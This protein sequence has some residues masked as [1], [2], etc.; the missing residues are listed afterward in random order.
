MKKKSARKSAFF[1]P[2][3]LIGLGL[4]LIGLLLALL[5]YTSYPG[6]SLLA[7]ES[8]QPA[9]QQEAWQ[10][11]WEVIPDSHHD[12][13]PPLRDLALLPMAPSSEHEGPENPSHHFNHA[14][15]DRPDPVVQTSK[16][17]NRLTANIPAPILNFDGQV[18]GVF[19]TIVCPDTNGYVGNTTQFAG[20]SPIG[21]Y[22]QTINRNYQIYDKF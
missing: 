9:P 15:K 8:S 1:N 6:A 13:S 7:H 22:A 16:L 12:L 4:C 10:P 17:L 11:H 3:A 14:G 18:D 20:G 2:R 5:A 19:N 21:Q